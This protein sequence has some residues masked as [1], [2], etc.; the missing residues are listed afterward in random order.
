MGFHALAE[1]HAVW[2]VFAHQMIQ[3]WRETEGNLVECVTASIKRLGKTSK[4]DCKNPSK[5]G[6]S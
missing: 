5:I 1:G 2:T 4:I 3:I 6:R